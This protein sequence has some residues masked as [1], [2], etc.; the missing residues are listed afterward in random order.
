[1][2]VEI[3]HQV[4]GDSKILSLCYLTFSNLTFDKKIN[5]QTSYLQGLT[6]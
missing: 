1:M 2:T 5:S 4:K 3:K 6:D